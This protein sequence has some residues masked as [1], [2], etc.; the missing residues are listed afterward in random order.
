[1]VHISSCTTVYIDATG[2]EE[3]RTIM[4]AEL[5]AIHSA[6]IKFATHDRLGTFTDSLSSLQAIRHHHTTPGTTGAKH[7]HHHMLLLRSITDLLETIRLAGLRT[8]LH[9]IRAHTI[10]RGND[11]A[12]AVAK[13]AVT[14]FDTLPPPQTLRVEIGETAPR[15]IHWVMYS[16]KPPPPPPALSTNTNCVTLRHPR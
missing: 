12:N 3:T 14:H 15:L 4:R 10:I 5:V 2:T 13:L 16:T 7:Y 1:V 11:L 6:L 8:T 9:K